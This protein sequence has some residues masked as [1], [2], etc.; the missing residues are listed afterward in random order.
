M[1]MRGR[2]SFAPQ[3]FVMDSAARAI[4]LRCG[5]PNRRYDVELAVALCLVHQRWT[6]VRI[7]VDDL[8]VEAI[9]AFVH[10]DCPARLDR[11]YRAAPCAQLAGA[12]AFR[13]ALQRHE[14]AQPAANRHYRA[15]RAE[16][17]AERAFDEQTGNEK[18]QRV[19]H[20]WPRAVHSQRDDGLE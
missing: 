3:I 15:K 12:A 2:R 11:L 1:V 16:K 17:A 6:H 19:R 4:S 5:G 9:E 20:E 8:A 7:V 14:A 13:A 10:V 18:H